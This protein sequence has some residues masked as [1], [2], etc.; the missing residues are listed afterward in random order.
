MEDIVVRDRLISGRLLLRRKYPGAKSLASQRQLSKNHGVAP[1]TV[2]TLEN[3]L[4]NLTPQQKES[5]IQA[6][7]HFYAHHP[8]HRKHFEG[9]ITLKLF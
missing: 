2:S 1:K 4:I 6:A 8:V 9:F 7:T 5:A 3:D